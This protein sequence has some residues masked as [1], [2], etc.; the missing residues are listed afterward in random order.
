VNFL[1]TTTI[2]VLAGIVTMISS[3]EKVLSVLENHTFVVP[4]TREEVQFKLLVLAI[5][6]VFAFFKFTWSMQLA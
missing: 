1:A 5:I 4:A 2:L 6:F 3:T